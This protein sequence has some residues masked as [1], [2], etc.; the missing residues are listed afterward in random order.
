[1]DVT[2]DWFT[3]NT[4]TLY[5]MVNEWALHFTIFN[6]IVFAKKTE[7]L[8][9]ILNN[10][11][12]NTFCFVKYFSQTSILLFKVYW[13]TLQK[14]HTCV[15]IISTKKLL[16]GNLTKGQAVKTVWIM[17]LLSYILATDVLTYFKLIPK[18]KKKIWTT[19]SVKKSIRIL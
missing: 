16:I 2:I 8:Y 3:R 17:A 7:K 12:T 10:A 5:I 1:M 14:L 11:T 15:L 9:M 4:H 6:F 13:N 19:F 18:K